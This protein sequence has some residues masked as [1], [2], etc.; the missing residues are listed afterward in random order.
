LDGKSAEVAMAKLATAGGVLTIADEEKEELA[1][2]TQE[3]AGMEEEEQ[4]S[5]CWK[6]S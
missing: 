4:N 3:E 1:A 6:R 2:G 5:P